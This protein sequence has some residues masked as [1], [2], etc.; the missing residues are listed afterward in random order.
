MVICGALS[1]AMPVGQRT[2]GTRSA[3]RIQCA[4]LVGAKRGVVAN[5]AARFPALAGGVSADAT[6]AAG[7]LLRGYGARP[8]GIAARI[9][10]TQRAAPRRRARQPHPAIDAGVG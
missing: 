4:A 6:V 9:C 1:D 5:D 8:E 10:R 2:T 3:R 7:W